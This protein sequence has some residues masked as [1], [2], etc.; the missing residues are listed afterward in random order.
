MATAL[1]KS[2]NSRDPAVRKQ[3]IKQAAKALDRSALKRLAVMCEEDPDPELRDLARRAGVYIREQLGELTPASDAPAATDEKDKA[4]AKIAVSD[5]QVER[6]KQA[7]DMAITQQLAG[8]KAKALK[9]LRQALA[10]NPNL[11]HDPYFLSVT[12]NVTGV[13]GKEA[14]SQLEDK[15][16]QTKVAEQERQTRRQQALD[17]HLSE[18]SKGN[19]QGVMFDTAIF[20]LV[21]AVTVILVTF[22]V[23][24]FSQGYLQKIVDNDEAVLDALARGA[25]ADDPNTGERTYFSTELDANQR[26][27]TFRA[28]N[29]DPVL[30]QHARNVSQAEFSAVFGLGVAA[31]LLSLIGALLASGMMDGLAKLLGGKGRWVYFAQ[32]W[33]GLLLSRVVLLG[34]V[35]TVGVLLI[36][37][38]NGGLLVSLVGGALGLIVLLLVFKLCGLVGQAY[39]M[40]FAKGLI[41][42]LSGAALLA[43]VV[44]VPLGI[45]F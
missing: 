14:I 27:R 4:P 42:G 30:E 34:I 1:H 26:P 5:E 37:E 39:H 2:L 33:F 35:T 24:Q 9:Y 19:V 31:G 6:G 16:T 20:T 25:F 28:F 38:S 3:A 40:G 22:L 43:L 7:I 44:A 45:L 10:V 8:E 18:V 36:Y 12:Q 13:D 15:T 29:P 41:S 21:S 11:R 17:A 32:Q 23:M